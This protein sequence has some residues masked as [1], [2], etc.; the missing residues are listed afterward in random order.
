[1]NIIE[2]VIPKAWQD[3]IL[4]Y[5]TQLPF[6]YGPG[7]SYQ[8]VIDGEK[9]SFVSGLD[10]LIDE[11]T[12]DTPQ[13]S[14]VSFYGKV[15]GPNTS[16]SYAEFRPLLYFIQE[17]LKKKITTLHR[18]KVNCLLQNPNCKIDNYNI[19]HVDTSN[20]NKNTL[21]AIYYA[22]D[23]DGDTF[24]FN[25]HSD[26]DNLIDN[27][28]IKERITPKMGSL[29]IFPSTQF[30]ASSNPMKTTSRFVINFMFDVEE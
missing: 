23:S 24:L 8:A 4:T 18:V 3:D 1:M 14:H 13:F 22:N 29:I 6:A 5:I 2:N 17:Y 25:E 15:N 9:L 26:K 11:K 27:L 28:T 10:Y 20:N 19:A 12:V 21:T 16:V 30:H 7:T